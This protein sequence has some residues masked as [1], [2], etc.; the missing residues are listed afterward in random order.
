MYAATGFLIVHRQVYRDMQHQLGLPWCNQRSGRPMMAP[1]FLPLIQCDDAGQW[2]LS[3][4]YSF[5]ER[6]RQCGYRISD[7]TT[8]RLG[9]I[10]QY[11][12]QWEDAGSSPARYDSYLYDLQ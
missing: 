10:G 1:F 3:E 6:A 5:C 7:D 9:H 8:I 4:D 12:Y 11:L 2:Y